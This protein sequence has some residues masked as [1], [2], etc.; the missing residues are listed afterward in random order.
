ML[1]H[2][3][4]KQVADYSFRQL[5]AAELLAVSD[6]LTECE[7]CRLRVEHELHGDTAFFA[8]H[9]EAFSENGTAV[10]HLT[11]EQTAAYVDQNL[12]GDELQAIDDHLLTCEQCVLEVE[13]LRVFRDEMAA[14]LD[15][16]YGPTRAADVTESG[17][18][19]KFVSLFTVSRVPAFATAALALL[20]FAGIGWLAWRTMRSAP[21]EVAVSPTPVPTPT[22][23]SSSQAQPAPAA[24]VAQL[25]DGG[26]VV[27]LDQDGKL[28]GAEAL[29]PAYQDLLKKALTSQKIE[30]PSQLQGLTRPRSSL[31]GSDNQ[32]KEFS[33]R[34]PVSSVLLTNRPT[35]RW[36]TMEGATGYV[37][38]VYDPQFKLV[39]SSPQLTTS[40]WTTTL[41]RG[42]IY[43]WQVKASKD[44]LE[45]TAPRPPAPQAKFRILDQAKVNELA[46]AKRAY[47]SAH[48][49]LG[50]LYAEAGLLKEAE[51]QFRLLQRANP[52]SPLPRNLLR[53]VQS[54]RTGLQD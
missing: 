52:T 7:A 39:S 35:F 22:A 21:Q 16:K 3:T 29:P 26:G 17:W 37:V 38:E 23:E 6:H 31:M 50:L 11:T 47:A 53:Q 33:L 2:L 19:R 13:D 41:E 12:A 34:E 45:V 49:I 5:R 36:S 40:S 27:T 32:T 4:Q 10:A 46:Q 54:M 42:K 44:G 48:L 8:L 25:N 43:S 51:Q 28:T 9:E 14:T 20:V 24:V 15:R 30:R 1:E 18:R